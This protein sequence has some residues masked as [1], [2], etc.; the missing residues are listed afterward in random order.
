MHADGEAGGAAFLHRGLEGEARGGGHGRGPFEGADEGIAG[1]RVGEGGEAGR[2]GRGLARAEPG[3]RGEIVAEGL[4]G[5]A[6]DL[7]VRGG[8]AREVLLAG[9]SLLPVQRQRSREGDGE[10]E[11]GDQERL[12]AR[13]RGGGGAAQEAQSRQGEDQQQRR[14]ADHRQAR[15]GDA[16]L[17]VGGGQIDA[18]DEHD[19]PGG[20]V[21]DR[22]EAGDEDAVFIGVGAVGDGAAG[23]EELEELRLGLPVDGARGRGLGVVGGEVFGPEEQLA[24]AQ[25]EGVDAA[26]PDD[27]P[28]G[29]ELGAE[30]LELGS[31]VVGGGEVEGGDLGRVDGV[32]E[33]GGLADHGAPQFP[34]GGAA[35]PVG[36]GP[37]GAEQ[38]EDGGGL[39]EHAAREVAAAH[40]EEGGSAGRGGGEG[41]RAREGQ[42]LGEG[43]GPAQ[44]QQFGPGRHGASGDQAAEAAIVDPLAR[45]AE[46][47]QPEAQGGGAGGEEQ[48]I[49]GGQDGGGRHGAKWVGDGARCAVSLSARSFRGLPGKTL[50]REWALA[51]ESEP[52]GAGCRVATHVGP[53]EAAQVRGSAARAGKA[54]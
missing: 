46:H 44:A 40:Q 21:E 36:R 1:E 53:G 25:R 2:I 3:Q 7:H 50:R 11:G 19:L 32:G 49:R 30:A 29:G 9:A 43:D 8:L 39:G 38:R 54:K 17:P 15:P 14:P 20:G 16:A 41:E 13:G 6:D 10:A 35:G 45:A 5:G 52:A 24:L 42:D 51:G 18:D 26:L 4:E 48:V 12:G 28:V 27:A 22:G 23:V 31:L 37:A 47:G 34:I 33:G